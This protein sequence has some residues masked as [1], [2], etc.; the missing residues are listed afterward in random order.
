M[1]PRDI[2]RTISP[3]LHMSPTLPMSPPLHNMSPTLNMIKLSLCFDFLQF[4]PDVK[5]HTLK[6]KLDAFT[7]SD[8]KNNIRDLEMVRVVTVR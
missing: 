2:T 5:T 6:C 4:S 1:R 7:K 3:T 8:L